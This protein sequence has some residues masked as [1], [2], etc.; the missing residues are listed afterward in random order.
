MCE[1]EP[2]KNV[3]EPRVQ[4]ERSGGWPREDWN[5]MIAKLLASNGKTAIKAKIE[6]N[7]KKR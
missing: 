3:W 1:N 5:G 7:E 4:N 6:A 2:L